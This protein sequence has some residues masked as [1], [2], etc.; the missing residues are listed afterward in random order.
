MEAA[1]LKFLAHLEAKSYLRGYASS[2]ACVSGLSAFHLLV[3]VCLFVCLFLWILN[4]GSV[5][6]TL[7]LGCTLG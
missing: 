2:K 7:L 1:R 4:P 3:A 5:Y 6:A